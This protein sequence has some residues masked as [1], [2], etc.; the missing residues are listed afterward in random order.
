MYLNSQLDQ[1]KLLMAFRLR[2][3]MVL[4]TPFS[5]EGAHQQL[6]DTICVHSKCLVLAHG[7]KFSPFHLM[8]CDHSSPMGVTCSDKLPVVQKA[9]VC[10]V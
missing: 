9:K 4:R 2:V 6:E 8:A 5:A 10:C 7:L 1:L 3:G